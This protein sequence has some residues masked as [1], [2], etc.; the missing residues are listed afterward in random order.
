M[1]EKMKLNGL[2]KNKE[3]RKKTLK[4]HFILQLS[5]FGIQKTDTK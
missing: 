3:N 5:Q 1:E 2:N 4:Y